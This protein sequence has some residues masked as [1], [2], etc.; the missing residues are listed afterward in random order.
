M[1]RCLPPVAGAAIALLLIGPAWAGNDETP[2]IQRGAYIA[3]IGDC[4]SCHTAPGREGFAGGL[5]LQAPFGTIFSTNITPDPKFGIGGY[6]RPQFIRAMR[7]GVAADGRHLYPAMPYASF[8][9]VSDDDL[10]DLYDYLMKSVKPA[11]YQPPKTKLVFPFN[12]RWGLIFWDAVFARHDRFVPDPSRDAQWNRGA[13]LVQG[14][15]HCGACHTPRG[16]AYEEEGY[17]QKSSS[18]LHGAVADKWA[19][20]NLTGDLGSGLGRWSEADVAAFLKT[21]HGGSAAAF[22]NMKEA[23]EKSTQHLTDDDAVAIAHYLKSFP[24]KEGAVA[25]QPSAA[26]IVNR[27]RADLSGE[28][29]LPGAGLF[30]S[31]CAGCHGK[32]GEGQLPRFPEI[33][34]NPVVLSADPISL[35]RIVLEGSTS[36][37]TAGGPK[38]EKMPAF[39]RLT[40]RE[41]AEVVTFARASWG[42]S[43][44]PVSEREVSLLRSQ[45]AETRKVQEEETKKANRQP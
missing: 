31:A 34:G 3:D 5:P 45:L 30:A 32:A 12:Q 15:G 21:G 29:E 13:Y 6:S 44:P 37:E 20:A 40:D 10:N 28:R 33:A 24:A 19:T 25:F 7:E 38:A 4:V 8:A 39:A 22:G 35:I 1:V 42:N 36:P 43:A 2:A 11:A 14:L 41:I 17:D 26:E 18:Y 23:V 27:D 9:V 16:L